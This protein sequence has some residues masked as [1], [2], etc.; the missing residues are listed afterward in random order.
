MN[1]T[2][3]STDY[4]ALEL[5]TKLSVVNVGIGF[6]SLGSDANVGFSTPLATLH[7]FQGFADKFLNTPNEGIDDLYLKASG[8]IGKLNMVASYHQ[9][10]SEVGSIDY[11]NEFNFNATYPVYKNTNFLLRY[12]NYSADDFAVDT[13][14]LWAMMTFTF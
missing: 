7:I 8:K 3:F 10:E 2:D 6:E 4:L 11:G 1:P 5:S 12:A 9:F 13:N 14:K